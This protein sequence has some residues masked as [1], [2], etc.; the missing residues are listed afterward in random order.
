MKNL[1]AIVVA[2]L[3]LAGCGSMQTNQR[4]SSLDETLNAYRILLRWAQY[5]DAM[6]YIRFRPGREPDAEPEAPDFEALKQVR[7][8]SYDIAEKVLLEDKNEANV[9]VMMSYY[10][11]DSNVL[12][13]LRQMQTW[14]YDEEKK[15]WYLEGTLPDLLGGMQRRD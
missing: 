12:H 15:R 7:L 10:A 2:V 11:S 4:A 3:V 14:W 9:R 13:S 8:A 6:T 1:A 5:E